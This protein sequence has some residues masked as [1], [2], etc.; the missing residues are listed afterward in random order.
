MLPPSSRR[1]LLSCLLLHVL[2]L[3]SPLLATATPTPPA[4][5]ALLP[6]SSLATF[7]QQQYNCDIHVSPTQLPCSGHGTCLLLL[8]VAANAS[9]AV[10][11]SSSASPQPLSQWPLDQPNLA[12]LSP[13]LTLCSCDSDW[14]GR[15]MFLNRHATDADTCVIS[16]NAVMGLNIFALIVS[17][18]GA[19]I[20]FARLWE[21]GQ[22]ARAKVSRQNRQLRGETV[23]QSAMSPTNRPTLIT[24]QPPLTAR[25]QSAPPLSPSNQPQSPTSNATSNS[26]SNSTSTTLNMARSS[27]THWLREARDS[28]FHAP[29]VILSF[30]L[31]CLAVFP[32][33]LADK[34]TV[35]GQSLSV[36]FFEVWASCMF[37]IIVC[38]TVHSILKLSSQVRKMDVRDQAMMRAINERLRVVCGVSCVVSISVIQLTFIMDAH[39][40]LIDVLITTI[41]L[42]RSAPY[43]VLAFVYVYYSGEVCRTLLHGIETLNHQQQSDRRSVVRKL[44]LSRYVFAYIASTHCTAILIIAFWP[45]AHSYIPY[46]FYLEWASCASICIARLSLLRPANNNG[47][48]KTNQVAAAPAIPHSSSLALSKA[49]A[50]DDAVRKSQ[51]PNV[52][53]GLGGDGGLTGALTVAAEATTGLHI[54]VVVEG[55]DEGAVG[56]GDSGEGVAGLPSRS[57]G[58][59]Q[60]SYVAAEAVDA[61]SMVQPP[62][63]ISVE[64]LP[65]SV[66]LVV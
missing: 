58:G 56:D 30:F 17:S 52:T 19:V 62:P 42:A 26:S 12:Y 61:G 41:M 27:L 57:I 16:L 11:H 22:K 1:R 48:K 37:G 38:V 45:V 44:K 53:D 10:L 32:P 18:Y 43:W 55:R 63:F 6:V 66:D 31:G 33:L 14:T 28:S 60:L 39:A 51:R 23:A 36:D 35:L 54:A 25:Q 64:D 20:S 21:W 9:V 34:R 7:Y 13:P 24:Q 5:W 59:G 3:C 15:S 29:A 8:D 4:S 2:F 40:E 46:G 65:G 49:R 47:A 50:A